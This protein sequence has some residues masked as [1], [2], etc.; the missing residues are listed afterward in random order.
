MSILRKARAAF[1]DGLREKTGLPPATHHAL[2]IDEETGHVQAIPG[3]WVTPEYLDARARCWEVNRLGG[4]HLRALMWM[5]SDPDSLEGADWAELF[6][7]W[8]REELDAPTWPIVPDRQLRRMVAS[9]TASRPGLRRL[10]RFCSD[11]VQ[12]EQAE[13][14]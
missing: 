14:N 3:K 1:K 9:A 7:D 10:L 12:V 11:C 5:A 4:A 6:W 8:V 13:G 2:R